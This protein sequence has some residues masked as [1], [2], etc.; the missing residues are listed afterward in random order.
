MT[1]IID[2]FPNRYM[3]VIWAEPGEEIARIDVRRREYSYGR[4]PY[5]RMY[6]EIVDLWVHDSRRRQGI[7]TR[8][9]AGAME[10]ARRNGYTHVAVEASAKPSSPGAP[11]YE[12][13]GFIPRSVIYDMEVLS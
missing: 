3:A 4:T 11:T 9:V 7:A 1:D 8:L 2:Q 10:W 13:M 5:R 12:S 6:A